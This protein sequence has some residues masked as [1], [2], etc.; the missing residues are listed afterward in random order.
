MNSYTE[1]AA[2]FV[3][4]FGELGPKSPSFR[5]AIRAMQTHPDLCERIPEWDEMLWLCIQEYLNGGG[6]PAKEDYFLHAVALLEAR[7]SM[8]PVGG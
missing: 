7:E 1:I 6:C 5:A 8:V 4:A 2:S 3:S